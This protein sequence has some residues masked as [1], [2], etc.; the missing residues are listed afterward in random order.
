MIEALHVCTIC[1]R[2][3]VQRP[4]VAQVWVELRGGER[5]GWWLC[6]EHK[7]IGLAEL[8]EFKAQHAQLRD[9]GVADSMR[10]RIIARRI[11]RKE[12]LAVLLG[13]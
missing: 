9:R 7:A 4:A 12:L 8:D 11:E 3:K 13:D 2:D 1:V 10:L 6:E 5:T